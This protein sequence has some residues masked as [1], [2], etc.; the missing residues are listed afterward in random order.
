MT[1]QWAGKDNADC[2]CI[3]NGSAFYYYPGWNGT[4]N[5]ATR[6]FTPDPNGPKIYISQ[7]YYYTGSFWAVMQT[8]DGKWTRA[9]HQSRLNLFNGVPASYNQTIIDTPS[10]N[11]GGGNIAV[12]NPSSGTGWQPANS[13]SVWID[14]VWAHSQG[15]T[16]GMEAV[17]EADPMHIGLHVDSA[18]GLHYSGML[19]LSEYAISEALS[20]DEIAGLH[21]VLRQQDLRRWATD[22]DKT[23]RLYYPSLDDSTIADF[24]GNGDDATWSG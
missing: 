17:Y 15:V 1:F 12:P 10:T 2:Q 19:N 14:G 18:G 11:K 20:G 16:D 7:E 22:N 3:R 21:T 4:Y 24:S 13:W 5:T 23:L 6:V 9:L 8:A